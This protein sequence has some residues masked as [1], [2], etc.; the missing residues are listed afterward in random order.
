MEL[1]N[2]SAVAKQL[3][4]QVKTLQAWRCRG[5]GPEFVRVGRLIR[6]NPNSVQEWISS[7]TA[8]ST[9]EK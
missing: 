9:S 2:E 5:G 1:L 4:C 8:R 7:R 6:Y 3:G